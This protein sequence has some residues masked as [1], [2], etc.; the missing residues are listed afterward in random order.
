MNCPTNIRPSSSSE[1]APTVNISAIIERNAINGMNCA[2]S[3]MT[4]RQKVLAVSVKSF[5]ICAFSP[6]IFSVTPNRMETKMICSMSR[7]TIGWT[8][9]SGTTFTIISSRDTLTPPPPS[10]TVPICG[11]PP[12]NIMRPITMLKN[13]AIT[14]V[15]I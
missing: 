7:L 15:H 11:T 6:S 8:R 13:V 12:W 10:V 9:F 3:V 1:S 2:K 5:S 14:V 4:R